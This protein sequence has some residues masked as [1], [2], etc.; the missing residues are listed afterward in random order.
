[1]IMIM[2]MI[3]IMIM[4]MIMMIIMIIIMNISVYVMV[5]STTVD[6]MFTFNHV[7]G[8]AKWKIKV[9]YSREFPLPMLVGRELPEYKEVWSYLRTWLNG[10]LILPASTIRQYG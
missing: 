5:N 1:M 3:M 9:F 6:P 2:K 8:I 10:S 7:S 4:I